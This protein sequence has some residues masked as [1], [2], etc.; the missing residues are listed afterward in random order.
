MED[1]PT[2]FTLGHSNHSIE[3]FLDLLGQHEIEVV[4]DVRSSPYCRCA[5]HFNK[6]P[7]QNELRERR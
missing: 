6:E 4:V 7:L 2:T 5:T 3:A 1:A